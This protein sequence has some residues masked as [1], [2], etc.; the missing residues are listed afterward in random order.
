MNVLRR[1]IL[2]GATAAGTLAMAA[3]LLGTGNAFAA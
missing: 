2:K 1:D 3:G